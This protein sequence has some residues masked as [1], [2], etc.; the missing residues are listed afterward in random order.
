MV[1]GGRVLPTLGR[2]AYMGTPARES[3]PRGAGVNDGIDISLD[4]GAAG[5][6]AG[7][8]MAWLFGAI[9]GAE[10]VIIGALVIWLTVLRIRSHLRRDRE[11]LKK[12]GRS[13]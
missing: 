8:V 6:G 4:V 11:E 7:T 5:A 2:L 1:R 12:E 9:Q 3:Q 10:A 13:G